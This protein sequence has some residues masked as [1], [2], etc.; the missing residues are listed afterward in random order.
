MK[1]TDFGCRNW[2][3]EGGLLTVA[4]AMLMCSAA[5]SGEVGRPGR[6]SDP[7]YYKAALKGKFDEALRLL[8]QSATKG[9]AGWHA[10]DHRIFRSLCLFGAGREKEAREL[11]QSAFSKP[12]SLSPFCDSAHALLT[13]RLTDQR[14][15]EERLSEAIRGQGHVVFALKG[16]VGPR[17]RLVFDN[18]AEYAFA[19][20]ETMIAVVPAGRYRVFYNNQCQERPDRRPVKPAGHKGIELTAITVRPWIRGQRFTA[21]LTPVPTV[22]IISPRIGSSLPQQ[23]AVLEVACPAELKYE[24]AVSALAPSPYSKQS[25]VEIW[26]VKSTGP[27]RIPFNR[28]GKAFEK[29]RKGAK[30]EVR[31]WWPVELPG[32]SGKRSEEYMRW[33]ASSFSVK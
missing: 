10:D 32:R 33:V 7:A 22:Q 9:P 1:A 19:A 30:Y 29:L 25:T 26:R 27:C 3:T 13:G 21:I 24:L 23:K 8:D 20:Q 6:V 15:G 18:G 12:S 17:A 14:A 11:A 2:A 4:V 31:V 5:A 16:E 28:D